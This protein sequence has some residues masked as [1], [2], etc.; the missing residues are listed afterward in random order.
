M[1]R[2]YN[3]VLAL[4]VG[5]RRIGLARVNMQVKLPCGLNTL[6]NDEDFVAKLKSFISEYSIEAIV[7]GLPRNL[8]GEETAQSKYV[9]EFTNQSLKPLDV[10]IIFQDETLTSKEAEYRLSGKINQKADIDR[11]AAIIILEDYIKGP[12]A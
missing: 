9:R 8:K 1:H 4:D 3:N 5:E 11:E 7:V 2:N 10:P 6:A 12:E